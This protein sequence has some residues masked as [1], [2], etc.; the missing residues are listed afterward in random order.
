MSE[1]ESES[2]SS[3]KKLPL[4]E[5]AQVVVLWESG[6]VTL[7]DLSDRFGISKGALHDGLKKRGSVKGS[8]AAE[9][10]TTTEDHLKSEA[11][12]KMEMVKTFRGEFHTYGD[13]I[14]KSTIKELQELLRE[15]PRSAETKRRIFTSLKY[16]AEIYATI[17]DQKFHL[18]DLYNEKEEDGQL[19]EITVVQ[20]TEDEIDAIK[21]RFDTVPLMDDDDTILEEARAALESME[22][23]ED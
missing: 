22:A 1:E 14:M 6:S 3:K 21:R 2:P 11:S 7:S 13:F 18:F 19:P 23:P 17:R 15:S 8:R 20:Y 12:R 5:W 16:S 4:A 10:A 9:F